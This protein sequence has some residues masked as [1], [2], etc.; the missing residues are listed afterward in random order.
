[1]DAVASHDRVLRSR[2]GHI[3][4]GP[5]ATCLFLNLIFGTAWKTSSGN[6]PMFNPSLH[7]KLKLII[8]RMCPSVVAAWDART[9]EPCFAM[10]TSK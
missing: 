3:T 5:E 4:G 1:M 8:R 10:A 9:E 7:P 2:I 6:I